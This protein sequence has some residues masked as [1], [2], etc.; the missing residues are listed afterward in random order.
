MSDYELGFSAAIDEVSRM[1]NAEHTWYQELWESNVEADVL[2]RQE[3]RI[4]MLH[5]VINRLDQVRQ[6]RR[7]R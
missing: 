2:H 3:V 6:I 4:R 7:G 5:K 1:F